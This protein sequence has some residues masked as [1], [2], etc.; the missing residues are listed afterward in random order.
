MAAKVNSH[1]TE[2]KRIMSLKSVNSFTNHKP[3][4]CFQ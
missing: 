1:G 2:L 4:S 3:F